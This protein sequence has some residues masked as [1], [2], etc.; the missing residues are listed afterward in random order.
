MGV[1]FHA[2]SLAGGYILGFGLLRSGRVRGIAR[3]GLHGGRRSPCLLYT[4]AAADE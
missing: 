4:A 2:A 3:H 1:R